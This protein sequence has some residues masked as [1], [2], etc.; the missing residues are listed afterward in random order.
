[1]NKTQQ[2]YQLMGKNSADH[3]LSLKCMKILPGLSLIMFH[4]INI[5]EKGQY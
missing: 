2:Y 3:I 5:I 4:K 1:M